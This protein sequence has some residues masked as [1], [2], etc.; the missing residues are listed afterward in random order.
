MRKILLDTNAYTKFL[1]GDEAVLE[2]LSKADN[3]FLSSIVLG[4]LFSGFKGGSK[5]IQNKRNL[6]KFLA[7]P[8][9]EVIDVTKETA[10]IFGEIKYQ[11]SKEGN[12]LPINDVW[13][14]ACAM[15][16][17]AVLI[18]YDT[19]FTKISGIRIWDILKN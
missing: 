6:E 3:V 2:Q 14:A 1:L 16:T 8:Q 13:I 18:T 7:K 12:P 10:E 5:E 11:L 4:E 9:I 19:H 15:E 17:G